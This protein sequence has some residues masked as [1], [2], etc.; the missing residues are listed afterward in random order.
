MEDARDTPVVE[1]DSADALVAPGAGE[2]AIRGGAVRVAGYAAGIL[3]SLV[4][5]TLV[6]RH[7]GIEQFGRYVT[8]VALV[9]ICMSLL[10]G[11]VMWMAVREY[12]VRQG[13][14]RDLVMR[15]L[16][17]LRLALT[18]FAAGVAIVFALIAGYDHVLLLG[19]AVAAA[20]VSIQALQP[21]ISVPLQVELRWSTLT[22]IDLGTQVVRVAG[23]LILVSVG[24]G[25]VPLLAA[26]IPS[27]VFS[28]LVTGA[29]ARG[30]VPREPA[31]HPKRWKA[32]VREQLPFAVVVAIGSVYF[33]L[34]VVVLQLIAPRIQTGYFATSYRVIEVLIM[35]PVLLVAAIFPILS[36]SAHEDSERH[37]Y[38][39]GKALE[40]ALIAGVL[41][42]LC[43]FLGAG[44]IIDVIAGAR[45]HGSIRVLEIQS[46]ALLGTFIA[47]TAGF[48]LLSMR[49]YRP[50]LLMSL[51][52]LVANVVLT[53]V[54][55]S[56]HGA[57]GA[58]VGAV[59]AEVLLALGL[60]AALR[61]AHAN[62]ALSPRVVLTLL[63]AAAA[64]AATLALPVPSVARVAIAVPLYLAIM[65]AAGAIPAPVIAAIRRRV[66]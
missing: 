42:V 5:A 33:R 54:L 51:T 8:T 34:T 50:L 46:F 1:L 48:A 10:E 11:G 21:L 17:G 65:L 23:L 60:L 37:A 40:V 26:A 44:F 4:S 13:R 22:L 12:T 59:A 38:V 6:V 39:V 56:A 55:G 14:D 36:R 16:L 43:V 28:M 47:Q 66:T 57:Q 18:L 24:A 58:A 41:L 61:R 19:T 3:L 30:A 15:D 2:A 53:L 62:L 25:L 20:A 35:V 64:A 52:T 29:V 31:F 27:A 45:G 9:T 49:R 32:L 63:P 7:L